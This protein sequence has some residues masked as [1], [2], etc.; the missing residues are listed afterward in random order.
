MK[1][2]PGHSGNPAGRPPGARNKKTLALEAAYE[3]KAEEAVNDIMERAKS[4]DPAAMRLC[5]ERAVPTGRHRRFAFALPPISTPEDAEAAID[6]VMDGLAEGVLSLPEVAELLRLVE[7]LL[8]M[9]ESMREMK[10]VRDFIARR[11]SAQAHEEDER[12]ESVTAED[13][14]EVEA[15]LRSLYSSVNAVFAEP[16][17]P[18]AGTHGRATADSNGPPP[19]GTQ[20][21]TPETIAA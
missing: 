2:Q 8:E 7:R 19:A 9:A 12:Q 16:G 3:A 5:M 11:P 15:A 18:P 14:A 6:A 13:A 17:E 20:R 1:F 10:R 4:G 21:T